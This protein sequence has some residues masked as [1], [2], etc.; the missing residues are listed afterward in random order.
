MSLFLQVPYKQHAFKE[1]VP[2]IY[3]RTMRIRF[4][5]ID[6]SPVDTFWAFEPNIFTTVERVSTV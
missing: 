5:K 4:D 1:Y 6:S 2:H 3:P